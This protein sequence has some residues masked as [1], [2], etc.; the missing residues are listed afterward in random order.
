MNASLRSITIGKAKVSIINLGEL[1]L[2]LAETMNVTESDSSAKYSKYFDRQLLF[3]S[4]S[5]FLALPGASIVVDPNDY[6]SSVPS[7]SPYRPRDYKPPQN[8]IVQLHQIRVRPEDVTHVVITHAHFDHYAGTMMAKNGKY[9]PSFPSARCY[10]SR[11]D[12]ENKETQ[13]ALLKPDS[14]VSRTLGILSKKGFLEL[15]PRDFDLL[16]D[17]KIIAAPGETPG[18]QIL[19]LHSEGETLYCIGDLFH[20]AVEVER[21]QWMA[22]WANPLSNL[23]SRISLIEAA[24]AENSILIAGHMP[25]G[26][27]ERSPTGAKWVEI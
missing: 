15:C 22:N 12:W 8:L 18:H 14:E 24:L 27:L 6:E 20:H 26:R 23:K 21:P 25:I 17:V 10:L 19:R 7:D 11:A 16:P 9:S 2:S 13:E 1:S 5:V 3:P 4:Q